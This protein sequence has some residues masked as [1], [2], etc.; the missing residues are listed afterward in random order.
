VE[1]PALDVKYHDWNAIHDHM[2]KTL[3][4]YGRCTVRGGGF[5]LGLEPRTE[6]GIN[7]RMLLINLRITATGES[8]GE[9]ETEYEQPWEDE[10]IQYNEVGFVVVGDMAAP[11]PSALQ[12]EDVF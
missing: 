12:I 11:A 7:P 9:Q 2:G 1:T 4:V 10:G 6:Q 3:R 8:P 5:A